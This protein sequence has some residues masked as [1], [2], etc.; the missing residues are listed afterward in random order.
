MPITYQ[1]DAS[2][3]ILRTWI[4]GRVT[5]VDL[6]EHLACIVADPTIG[7]P[8]REIVDMTGAERVDFSSDLL[9]QLAIAASHHG[10]RFGG[11]RT[12]IVA[13]TDTTFGI[14]RMYELLADAASSPIA[15]SVFRSRDA[16][17][18]WLQER[19]ART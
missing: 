11:M 5:D 2:A 6:T 14:S 15:V 1:W 16:A 19:G 12:A 7:A 3:R 17:E 18:V 4:S 10:P 8:L 9:Q 13:P